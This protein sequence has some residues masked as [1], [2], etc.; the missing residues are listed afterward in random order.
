MIFTMF[1]TL[2]SLLRVCRVCTSERYCSGVVF[3]LALG[4]TLTAIISSFLTSS[5][6]LSLS[7]LSPSFLRIFPRKH[8]PKLPLPSSRN[9]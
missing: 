5:S 6:K 4:M 3:L 8:F 9:Y 7:R 2:G 1:F